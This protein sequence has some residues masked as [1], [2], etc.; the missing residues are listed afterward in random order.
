MSDQEQLVVR[1][2]R[3]R[4]LSAEVLHLTFERTDGRTIVF[5]P[6]QYICLNKKFDGKSLKGYYSLASRPYS[7]NFE[8]CVRVHKMGG[9]FGEL[10]TKCHLGEIF[11]VEFPEGSFRLRDPLRPSVFA[12]HGTGIAPVRSM[13]QHLLKNS[14]E[15]P[16]VPLTLLQGARTKEDLHYFVE[17]E[18]FMQYHSIF[19]YWPILSEQSS[20]WT[21]RTGRVQGHLREALGSELKDMN[22]YLCGSSDMVKTTVEQ[23]QA[24]KFNERA[25]V[26]EKY[27]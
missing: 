19:Q 22:V 6:G 14:A 16:D 12:V 4:N 20:E 23:L 21:G 27:A 13:L 3:R 17:F 25:I 26:Y 10:L 1:L 11:S 24:W 2:N 9:E 5:E 8:L 15:S 7:D 18:E